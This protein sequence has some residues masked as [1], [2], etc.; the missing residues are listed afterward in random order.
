MAEFKQAMNAEPLFKANS[1]R[2]KDDLRKSSRKIGGAG[3]SGNLVRPEKVDTQKLIATSSRNLVTQAQAD[4]M[5]QAP[6]LSAIQITSKTLRG[7]GSSAQGVRKDGISVVQSVNFTLNSETSPKS[8]NGEKIQE[9]QNEAFGFKSSRSSVNHNVK[10]YKPLFDDKIIEQRGKS[11]GVTSNNTSRESSM[12]QQR[13]ERL[14]SHLNQHLARPSN[15]RASNDAVNIS[16][17][18]LQR[19]SSNPHG[20]T[21]V[22]SISREPPK[23]EINVHPARQS[24]LSSFDKGTPR[25]SD[26]DKRKL[27]EALS[28]LTRIN[29]SLNQDLANTKSLLKSKDDEV[30][31]IRSQLLL[32]QQDFDSLSQVCQKEKQNLEMIKSQFSTVQAAYG[33]VVNS[34]HHKDVMSLAK[35]NEAL[36][37][38]LTGL[39]SLKQM[40]PTGTG[41]SSHQRTELEQHKI[42]VGKLNLKVK[43]LEEE[44]SNKNKQL[45]SISN[46]RQF[47]SPLSEVAKRHNPERQVEDSQLSKQIYIIQ[48]LVEKIEAEEK[49]ARALET[50]MLKASQEKIN[51][52][53]IIELTALLE[54]KQRWTQTIVAR[55]ASSHSSHSEF[56]SDRQSSQAAQRQTSDSVKDSL[57][58]FNFKKSK[59]NISTDS[60]PGDSSVNTSNKIEWYRQVKNGKLKDQDSRN[61]KEKDRDD[62][63]VVD[64]KQLQAE[65]SELH[66]EDRSNLESRRSSIAQSE[67]SISKII[68]QYK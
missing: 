63:V 37:F 2:M 17:S 60:R 7:S 62:E 26:T 41:S 53:W 38:E 56:M 5:G 19:L 1:L 9:K 50:E 32:K 18:Y 42:E 16:S 61:G 15:E 31:L 45:E 8:K 12:I 40:S 66:S 65:S 68:T 11:V 54:L 22:Y 30:S 46:S 52:R 43:I 6:K 58:L 21:N 67:E 13:G 49:R 44:L 25:F 51:E 39:S 3:G 55:E 4:I 36:K 14:S 34:Q 48:H 35:E 29:A 24:L 33:S 20:M 27:E 64:L 28:E 47:I 57:D 10:S 23:S 59:G